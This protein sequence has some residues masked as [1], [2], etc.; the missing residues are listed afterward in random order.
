MAAPS[1]GGGYWITNS[2][3]LVSNFGASTFWGS[4][5][6][7]L[8]APIV[9]VAAADGSGDPGNTAYQSGSF[10][11]DIS[12]WQCKTPFPPSPHQIG[13]V[14][15]DGSSGGTAPN[16]CLAT[17]AA[18]AGGGLGLYTFLTYGTT[19]K[20]LDHGCTQTAAPAAC[21]YGFLSATAA[22]TQAKADGLDPLVSWWLDIE[23]GAG[24]SSTFWSQTVNANAAVVTGAVDG[25][26]AEGV[27]TV[28]FYFSASTWNNIVGQFN[29]SG[30]LWIASWWT[31]TTHNPTPKWTCTTG[32]AYWAT[33]AHGGVT[34][35][36]GPV[37]LVQYT[38]NAG[39]FDGD[40]AC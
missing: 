7:V 12:S 1:T 33:Q 15:V 21:N 25:L 34:W 16:P 10:G 26:H 36:S 3:G 28:G 8:D 18:W 24:G 30:P 5:P 35:P 27:N 19:T 39:G 23:R 9:G 29:P 11:Y 2:N 20:V 38:D 32:R 37:D 31:P 17:E 40:Y 6:Q 22:F 4:A 14:E 13:I